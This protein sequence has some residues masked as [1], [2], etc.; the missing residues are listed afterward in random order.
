MTGS[1]Y[2]SLLRNSPQ[3]AH[4]AIFDEYFNYAYT[5]VFN[6]LRSVAGTEDVEECVSDVFAEVF[7]NYSEDDKGDK[8]MKGYIATIAQRRAID[9]FRSISV[10][11]GRSVSLEGDVLTELKAEEDI[12]ENSEKK[13]VQ[14]TL[15]Q[16][17]KELGEPDSTIILHK[18][19]Y[20]RSSGE[21]AKLLNMKATNVRMRCKRALEKLRLMLKVSG[22]DL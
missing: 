17:I 22:I 18:Y 15:I 9:R 12:V 13:D 4:K 21:I 8:D 10:K 1:E 11:N 3:Q 5:I 14:L 20:D 6:R 7:F 19:Y 2:C 16:L